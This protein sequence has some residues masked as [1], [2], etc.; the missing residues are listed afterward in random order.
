MRKITQEIVQTFLNNQIKTFGNT[1]VRRDTKMANVLCI[2]LHGNL[3]AKKIQK[4]LFITHANWP[5]MTTK[6][7]L[8]GLPGVSIKQK[9]GQWYLNGKQWDGSWIKV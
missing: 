6:E 2:S 5:T 4:D 9:A 1:S 8:N 7:R 3:I